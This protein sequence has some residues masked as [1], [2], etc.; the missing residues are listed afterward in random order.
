[1]VRIRVDDIEMKEPGIIYPYKFTGVNDLPKICQEPC[2]W[3]WSDKNSIHD[4][5]Y[6]ESNI[7]EYGVWTGIEKYQTFMKSPVNKCS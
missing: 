6:V 3:V 1:M 7:S 4:K 2:V 5:F